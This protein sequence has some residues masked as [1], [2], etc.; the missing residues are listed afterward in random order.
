VE[1]KAGMRHLLGHG[2]ITAVFCGLVAG[3]LTLARGGAW[4]THLVYSLA[5][6][7]VSW[8]FID[9]TRLLVTRRQEVRWPRGL[10]GY[11]V[12]GAGIGIGFLGGNLIGDAWVGAPACA[13]SSTAW[14]AAGTCRAGSTRR[15]APPPRPA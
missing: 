7:L 13:S 12:V 8:L 11:L 1:Y 14:A 9:V 3:A 15:S 6:G 10:G 5:T 4:T 2:L